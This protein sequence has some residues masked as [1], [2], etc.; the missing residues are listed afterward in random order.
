[1]T[2][3]LLDLRNLHITLPTE[4]GDLHAVRGVDLKIEP[5]QTLCLVG[6]SGCGKSLTASALMGLTPR[7]ART[8]AGSYNVCGNDITDVDS[9]ALKRLRG[10]AMAMIFQD[11]TAALNP[12]L[13][14]G[15]QLTE[16]VMLREKLS[17][18]EA[19]TRAINLLERVG[20]ARAETRLARYPHEFSGGQRQRVMIAQAL[21]SQPRLLIADEPTTALD[22]T[23]Q[24]Q[25]LVLLKELQDELG[26][27][28]LLITHDLGVVAAVA[29]EVSV[30]YAGRIVEHADCDALFD[31][32]FHPYTQGLMRAIPVPGVTPRGSHL[33]AIPGR[34]PSLI[35]EMPGCA[36]RERCSSAGADCERGS[37]PLHRVQSIGKSERSFECHRVEGGPLA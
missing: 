12:T 34:V 16:A 2:E 11:P 15:Q 35:G 20:I 25:I 29:D 14:I 19:D 10:D 26:L 33:P 27:G 37:V 5:A 17:H 4:Q 13:T 36:F 7:Y 31:L 1:M 24:A 3:T 32:P 8:R 6:E 30:M 22:V 23:I 18:A 21:M 9:P 28:I